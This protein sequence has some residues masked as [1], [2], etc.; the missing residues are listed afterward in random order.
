[1]FLMV[2]VFLPDSGY[3]DARA[4]DRCPDPDTLPAAFPESSYLDAAFPGF[5]L[6]GKAGK[7]PGAGHQLRP[8]RLEI[9]FTSSSGSTGFETCT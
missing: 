7:P 2:G 8:A 3:A 6:A 9:T 5:R 4:W 1:M